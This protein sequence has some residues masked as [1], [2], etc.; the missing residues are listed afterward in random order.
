[1]ASESR[2]RG[3]VLVSQGARSSEEARLA[4][5][6]DDVCRGNHLALGDHGCF[7]SKKA[8]LGENP[9]DKGF[10]IRT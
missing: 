5:S 1:M 6:R 4:T 10:Q 7:L 8:S 3:W 2:F 9:L